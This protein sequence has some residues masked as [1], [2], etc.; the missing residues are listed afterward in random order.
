MI[1]QVSFSNAAE[2]LKVEPEKVD[3]GKFSTF[4]IK[5]TVVKLK[6]TGKE[7]IILDKIKPDCSC[8]Q[9][10]IDTNE[11]LPGKTIELT[12]YARSTKGGILSHYILI[13]PKDKER[14][15]TLKIQITGT[16]IESISTEIGLTRNSIKNFKPDDMVD[17]GIVHQQSVKPIIYL[18]SNDKQFDLKDSVPDVN[19]LHFALESYQYEKI[20]LPY[21]EKKNIINNK[22]LV[23][24]LAPK[25]IVKTGNIKETVKI[26]LFKDILL[27]IRFSCLIVG[28]IYTNEQKIS[29]GT[30][31]DCTDKEV[32]INFTNNTKVWDNIKWSI[33][34]DLSS[35]II[36]NTEKDR[37]NDSTII[38]KLSIDK[39]KINNLPKGYLFSRITFYQNETTKENAVYLLVDGFN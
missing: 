12:V 11:I 38:V 23:L 33:D 22:R 4:Q 20:S 25:A 39:S 13:I 27:Y 36:A 10:S 3:F 28:D 32:L 15:E 21:P 9:T 7:K 26:Q 2:T 17:L 34:G 30:L 35:V 8:I 1:L 6:N 19:S 29:F 16:V 37:N 14:Y 5:E 18:Y 31:A 24:N